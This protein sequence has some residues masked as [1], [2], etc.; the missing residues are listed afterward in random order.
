MTQKGE[1]PWNQRLVVFP[2]PLWNSM[3]DTWSG[4]WESNPRGRRFRAFK[5]GGFARL[6]MPSV[7]SVFPALSLKVRITG[8]SWL[9]L[10]ESELLCD[11]GFARTLRGETLAPFGDDELLKV[12]YR[13]PILGRLKLTQIFCFALVVHR[14]VHEARFD[15]YEVD[16]K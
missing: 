10:Y 8:S 9:R 7:I 12:L 5:T 3:E 16:A 13:V 6:L 4:R 15:H 1:I 14:R 2:G 11:N